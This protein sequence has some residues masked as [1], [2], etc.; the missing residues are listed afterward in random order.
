MM[1]SGYHENVYRCLRVN[2]AKGDKIG[3][4]QHDIG[5]DFPHSN[6]AEQAVSHYIIFPRLSRDGN[7]TPLIG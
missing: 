1:L 3:I 2:I 7:P 6:G 4:L 5:R